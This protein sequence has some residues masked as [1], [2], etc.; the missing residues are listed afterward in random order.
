[1]FRLLNARH[2]IAAA[3]FSA[4]LIAGNTAPAGACETPRCVWKIITTYETV[5]Q[6][7]VNWVTRYDH[8]GKPY[9]VKV[10]SYETIQVPV[11][12][13]VKVCY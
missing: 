8:C 10:V 9:R 2:T 4:S 13:R 3:L 5:E 1:M 11:E 6:P 12:Q 7:V